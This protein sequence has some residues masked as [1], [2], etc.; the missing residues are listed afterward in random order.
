MNSLA[1]KCIGISDPGPRASLVWRGCT[2]SRER[3]M[4]LKRCLDNTVPFLVSHQRVADPGPV[5]LTVW[6]QTRSWSEHPYPCKSKCHLA[7]YC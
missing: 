2:M 3:N 4:I 1:T 7:I 6:I 5:F